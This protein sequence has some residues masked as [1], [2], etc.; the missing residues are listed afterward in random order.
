MKKN[1]FIEKN[2]Y[3][4]VTSLCTV[5]RIHRDGEKTNRDPT[6]DGTSS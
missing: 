5:R 6:S 4:E 1:A 2:R 3:R